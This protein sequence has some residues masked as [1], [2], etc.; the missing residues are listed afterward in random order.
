[1]QLTAR[2]KRNVRPPVRFASAESSA[3][4]L[5]SQSLAFAPNSA[6]PRLPRAN[7]PSYLAPVR[8]KARVP[9]PIT[10]GVIV[11]SS[12]GGYC[13]SN[14][15]RDS[16][17]SEPTL[18]RAASCCIVAIRG[19]QTQVSRD[20]RDELIVKKI[21]ARDSSNTLVAPPTAENEIAYST[22]CF[23]FPSFEMCAVKQFGDR[24]TVARALDVPAAKPLSV[25]DSC[26]KPLTTDVICTRDSSTSRA[27]PRTKSHSAHDDPHTPRVMR[28]SWCSPRFVS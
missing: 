17:N 7:L 15:I 1:M 20:S 24:R 28:A 3:V 9:V 14:S 2:P 23:R 12:Y 21:S 25:H 5:P 27:A 6:Q 13:V 16:T 26:A 22:H 19:P 8:K 10:S 11:T 4:L 18:L